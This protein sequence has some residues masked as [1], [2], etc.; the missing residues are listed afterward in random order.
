MVILTLVG[1]RPQIIKEAAL[2]M[3]LNTT[4]DIQ[5]ILVHS[6]QHY[7][8]NMSDV[9][10]RTLGMRQPKYNLGVGSGTHAQITGKIILGFEPIVLEEKPDVIL[11]YGDTDT[12]IAGAL[13]GAKL[14]IPVAHVEAGMRT[15]SKGVPEEI[16]AILTDHVSTYLFAP[17]LLAV[18][19]LARENIVDGVYFVGD[20]MYDLFLRMQPY[21]NYSILDK[22]DLQDNNY[23]VA[24][25]HRDYNTDDPTRLQ[26]ILTSLQNL[27]MRV[28][29]PLHPRT[30]KRIQEFG[31]TL[32]GLDIIE[33]LDYLSMMGLVSKCAFVITDSGGLQKE[34]YYCHKRAI[35]ISQDTAWKE[36]IGWNILSYDNIFVLDV[37][38][39]YR[40]DI[41]G[42]G[43]T[44]EQIINILRTS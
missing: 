34:A 2:Q 25:I 6:G 31:Y 11:V 40:A 29:M 22:L 5:E 24:T 16:N 23:I 7:D 36:L 12:T 41:Y 13:V 27:P 20:I 8:Y 18:Q 28:V 19:N 44:A 35:V 15:N 14:K 32:D 21:F 9:F 26:W 4:P 3:Y 39:E 17:S 43:N 10:F 33:P 30:R 37:C 38:I 1:P 42:A